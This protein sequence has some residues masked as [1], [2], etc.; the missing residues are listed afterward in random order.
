VR[1]SL[2][3]YAVGFT[4]PLGYAV[5]RWT[6]LG[7]LG[8][9]DAGYLAAAFTVAMGVRT[10]FAAASTQYLLPR[11]S[12]ERPK[13]ERAAEVARYIRTLLLLLVLAALPLLLFPRE[14]LVALYSREF[15][16]ATDVIGLFILAELVMAIGDAYRVLQ[17]G[18]DDLVGYFL[19]TCGAVVVVALNA[20]WV[21]AAYG[22]RGAAMLQVVAALAALVWSIGRIRVRHGIALHRR[23]MLATAYALG[24]LTLAALLGRA[25][26]DSVASAVAAKAAVGVLL[27]IGAWRMLPSEERDGVIASLPAILRPGRRGR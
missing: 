14:L 4:V 27:A 23:S 20:S 17:L 3:L 22:L 15:V 10:T 24:A 2:T 11:T 16:T 9:R 18:L 13:E 25:A 7:Q 6:V 21:V 1:F 8:E 5:L 19:T 26:P 12:R